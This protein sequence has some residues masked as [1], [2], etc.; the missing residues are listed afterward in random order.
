MDST[1]LND[2]GTRSGARGSSAM[3]YHQPRLVP[4]DL[5]SP[6]GPRAVGP[7]ASLASAHGSLVAWAPARPL[8]S[9]LPALVLAPLIGPELL[10]GGDRSK[11]PFSFP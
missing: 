10:Q 3:Q 7:P 2:K 4:R 6:P 1:L 9:P 11:H 8:H 5:R